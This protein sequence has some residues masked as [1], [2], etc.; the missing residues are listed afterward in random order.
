MKE[1]KDMKKKRE[2]H[3]ELVDE[4]QNG[5]RFGNRQAQDEFI[6]FID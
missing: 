2:N 5:H 3:K 1:K 6:S 4:C